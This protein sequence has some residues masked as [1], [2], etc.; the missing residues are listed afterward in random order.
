MVHE[1]KK[2]V[3]ADFEELHRMEQMGL[4]DYSIICP[5][6]PIIGAVVIVDAFSS[7]ANLAAMVVEWG[8]RVILVSAKRTPLFLI[9]SQWHQSRAYS[10]CA[11]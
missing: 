8:Y 1:S 7:G 9:S 10:Y 11:A 4:I 3:D 2:Q 6:P 5:E